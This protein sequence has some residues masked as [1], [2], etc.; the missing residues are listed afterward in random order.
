MKKTLVASSLMALFVTTQ[1]TSCGGGSGSSSAS[2]CPETGPYACKSGASEPLYLYQWALNAAQSFFKDFPLVSD[3]N[4]D[5]NV[6][7][8]HTQ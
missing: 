5:L 1:L 2:N 6:E 7:D 8:V 3:G 4:T